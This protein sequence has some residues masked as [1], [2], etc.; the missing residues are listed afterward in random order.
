MKLGLSKYYKIVA[1]DVEQII[2][3]NVKGS[4]EYYAFK[5]GDIINFDDELV[6]KAALANRVKVDYNKGIHEILK[7]DKETV[8]INKRS[9]CCGGTESF[10]MEFS[11][12]KEIK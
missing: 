4:F 8:N 5:P 11:Q 9:A 10:V 2:T 1:P 6:A 7:A 3:I 12:V